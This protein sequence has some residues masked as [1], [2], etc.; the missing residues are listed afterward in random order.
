MRFLQ[1]G[2]G[3]AYAGRRANVNPEPRPL[4]LLQR[5]EHLFGGRTFRRHAHSL[6]AANGPVP[7]FTVFLRTFGM[8]LMAAGTTMSPCGCVRGGSSR[9]ASPA[10]SPLSP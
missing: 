4:C 7:L 6:L 8:L 9:P 2:V 3:L 5:R 1:H 10:W